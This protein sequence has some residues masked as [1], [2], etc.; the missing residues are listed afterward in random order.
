[1][2]NWLAIKKDYRKIFVILFLLHLLYVLPLII[3]SRPFNDDLARSLYGLSGWDGDVR[4]VT[5]AIALFFSGASGIAVDVA[6][7]PLFIA[8]A[9]V[10]YVV[11]IYFQGRL[12]EY[13]LNHNV[14]YALLQVMINPFLLYILVFRY[15]CGP[16]IISVCIAI[17][18]GAVSVETQKWKYYIFSG[19]ASMVLMCIYQP[20][21]GVFLVL[22]AIEV[23][24]YLYEKESSEE[25]KTRFCGLL[26]AGIGLLLYV[27]II[28]GNHEFEEGDWRVSESKMVGVDFQS[29]I[30]IKSNIYRFLSLIHHHLG[31]YPKWYKVVF[32]ISFIVIVLCL[33][34]H[35]L[36]RKYDKR[37]KKVFSTIYIIISPMILVGVSF[38][39]LIF[40]EET[41]FSSRLLI[42]TSGC[43]LFVGILF[44]IFSREH[45]YLATTIMVLCGI[46]QFS[47]VYCLGNAMSSQMEYEKY[48]AYNMAKNAESIM[49]EC[50]G[51]EYISV[52][53][54]TPYAPETKMI[55]ETYRNMDELVPRYITNNWWIGG[56]W[57]Q[58]Y[59]QEELEWIYCDISSEELHAKC[60]Y[61]ENVTYSM[62]YDETN[63]YIEYR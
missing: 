48:L 9:F 50:D 35:V 34:A 30:K 61:E 53:G 51:I 29:I 60:L 45:K 63:I 33:L 15:D 49:A 16:V 31:G 38:L 58:R 54:E 32:I 19:V 26:S 12:C 39:A 24:F 5:Q 22:F 43:M 27:F 46:L 21:I 2:L 1:M 62:Y 10:A 57:L 52:I 17:L 11:T 3:A 20:S 25:L 7:M 23:F 6:P 4:P 55:M 18:W 56:A 13:D 42:S 44:I 37:W 59:I 41:N 28:V 47:Y 14:I 36:T 8:C 40:S